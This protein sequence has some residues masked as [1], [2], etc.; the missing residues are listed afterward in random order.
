[1]AKAPRSRNDAQSGSRPDARSLVDAIE[2]S[3]RLGD[4]DE[5]LR[6][7]DVLR[8]SGQMTLRDWLALGDTLDGCGQFSQAFAAYQIAASID[9]TSASARLGLGNALAS[10]GRPLEALVEYEK[11]VQLESGSAALWANYG[12][13]LASLGRTEKALVCYDRALAIAPALIPALVSRGNAKAM[14]NLFEDA[15]A[16]HLAAVTLKP[17]SPLALFNFSLSCLRKG[18]WEKGFRLYE[19]RWEIARGSI[20]KKSASGLW[21]GDDEI[22]G[23]TLLIEAEQGLGD[24]LMFCRFIPSVIDRGATVTIRAPRSL[25]GILRT[26]DARATV[27]AAE[28]HKTWNANR[29]IP[30]ASLPLACR[31]TPATVPAPPYLAVEDSPPRDWCER[32]N[33]A[34]RRIGIVWSGGTA[35]GNVRGRSIPLRELLNATIGSGEIVALQK[36]AT[37]SERALLA[38]HNVAFFG[39]KFTSF[40]ETAALAR[41][42][43]LVITIDTS[44][45]HLVGGMSIPMWVLLPY[46]SDWRWSCFDGR[47]PWYPNARLWRQPAVDDWATVLQL[48]KHALSVSND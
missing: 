19:A 44:V 23:K 1:M 34:K 45:A 37:K 25:E 28:D 21:L 27:I 38:K 20:R 26:V 18:E 2:A 3:G 46:F 17:D 5:M 30:M 6:L 32:P 10:L 8:R 48:V 40:A 24:T 29:Y 39:D 47:N 13:T 22:R 7:Y 4:T 41:T 16:D 33:T 15:Y 11:G 14:L 35:L 42:C 43:D 9:R 12:A 36:E 31:T